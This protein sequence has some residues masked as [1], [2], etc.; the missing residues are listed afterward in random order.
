MPRIL[1]IAGSDSGGGAGIQADLKTILALGGYGMS[2]ITAVTAQ[3]TR[4]V[5]RAEALSPDLVIAQLDAVMDDIGVDAMKTGMLANA[6]IVEAVADRLDRYGARNIVVDPVMAAKSGD[7]L[8]AA[9]ARDTLKKKLVPLC[10][11]LT[12]N[13]P[14]A[15]LL[16]G[17]PVRPDAPEDTLK[18]LKDLGPFWVLLKGGH[19]EGTDVTDFLYDGTDIRVYRH[20]RYA[21]RNTHGTGCT[22]SAAI[23]TMLGFGFSVPE[24][25]RRAKD[26]L[27]EAIRRAD[28]LRVGQGYGPLHHGWPVSSPKKM[29]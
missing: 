22:F 17:R 28:E 2:V 21:T 7:P 3:N 26:Y 4:G 27:S 6:A 1:T 13:I 10:A 24:S 9:D 5:T 15:E 8:L 19:A 25:V 18:A 29:E 11:V 23:A 14:E 12:P 16:T 20:T